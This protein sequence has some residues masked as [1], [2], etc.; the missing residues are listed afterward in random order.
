MVDGQ[1]LAGRGARRVGARAREALPELGVVEDQAHAVVRDVQL[2]GLRRVRGRGEVGADPRR[3]PRPRVRTDGELGVME[4]AGDGVLPVE[5]G[6]AV[7]AQEGVRD[8][9]LVDGE[10]GSALDVDALADVEGEVRIRALHAEARVHVDARHALFRTA[11]DKPRGAGREVAGRR[12]VGDLPGPVRRRPVAARVVDTL[13]AG[14]AT[15]IGTLRL[16]DG[17]A[18]QE[19]ARHLAQQG[20]HRLRQNDVQ[21]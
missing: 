6:A 1:G 19:L 4:G 13:R 7:R 15:D 18:P 17:P 8:A 12:L 11:P 9:H 2:V 5:E 21:N 3:Q 16:T 20:S 14:A 10:L